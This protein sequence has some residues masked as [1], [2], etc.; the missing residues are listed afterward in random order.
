MNAQEAVS[1][2][3][4][5]TA[6]EWETIFAYEQEVEAEKRRLAVRAA[7]LRQ[8][9]Q[10]L[11]PPLQFVVE[12]L[13]ESLLEDPPEERWVIDSVLPEGAFVL[14][15]AQHKTG[16]TTAM[17][18]LAT[19]LLRGDSFLGNN[20]R[21][22]Y[23]RNVLYLNADMPK[24][25]FCKYAENL[26]TPAGLK[27]MHIGPNVF[28]VENDEHMTQ[29]ADQCAEQNVGVLIIDVWGTVYRGDE[30][31]NSQVRQAANKLSQLRDA[32]GLDALV[33]L[34]HTGWGD[35]GRARGASSFEGAADVIW[36]LMRSGGEV[37]FQAN[38]RISPVP[39]VT[40][41]FDPHTWKVS[42]GAGRSVGNVK[43]QI[44][45]LM[46]QRVLDAVRAEPG[47]RTRHL[48][49]RVPGRNLDIAAATQSLVDEGLVYT[50]QE[51][52]G[53]RHYPVEVTGS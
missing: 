19:S 48:R 35:S 42:A 27:V 38:G 29:L 45:D 18:N 52:Q 9:Q 5:H 1:T 34:H 21:A 13:A 53:V 11:S 50:E 46:K 43:A 37:T 51:G 12:D 6:A 23:D 26:G 10:T 8:H 4:L 15:V 40:V 36:R 32:A 28:D 7:A 22:S 31:D 30:N 14:C 17:L 33:I 24:A 47:I 2:E 49:G 16:K 41:E 3:P 25:M 44:E 20:V 39:K